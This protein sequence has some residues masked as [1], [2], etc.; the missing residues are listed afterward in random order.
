MALADQSTPAEPSEP[1]RA[2][3]TFGS[4]ATVLSR[5]GQIALAGVLLA[6]VASLTFTTYGYLASHRLLIAETAALERAEAALSA[7]QD[8]AADQQASIVRLGRGQRA[9]ERTL[10]ARM[11]ELARV[12]RER[13]AAR[14]GIDELGAQVAALERERNEVQ[15]RLGEALAERAALR[16]QLEATEGQ[17]I[18]IGQQWESRRRTEDGL[19]WRI[20]RLKSRLEHLAEDRDTTQLWFKDWVI[21]NITALQQLFVGTGIDLDLLM[22]RAVERDGG[23]GG[24]FE[25]FESAP[26][27]SASEADAAIVA[28]IQ[29]L[30]ALQKL[31]NALPL[32][33]PL[34]HFH[35]TSSFGKRH[36]PFR[37]NLAFHT[38]LDFGAA[39]GSQIL[40][41]APGEVLH[42]GPAGPYGN[43]VEIDHGM[44]VVTRFGH[45]RS[46]LV[47]EGETIGFRQPIGVI[48]ST[49]RSTGRHLHYEVRIDGLPYDPAKFLE[50]GRNLVDVLN[51]GQRGAAGGTGEG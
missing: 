35:I 30:S 4:A 15:D 32:A 5:S 40:A 7:L 25:S 1:A 8:G 44:G 14:A 51:F 6:G 12:S 24:P 28:H 47:S 49:G 45:L 46:V 17:V 33:A 21:R 2:L 9:L 36:D 31:A 10:E 3:R 50:A 26:S 11:R 13:D 22:A 34:D 38:G 23:L 41:T 20:A 43:L 27:G 29:R 48:G 18:Q 37:R 42:A 16:E 39:R 19:R